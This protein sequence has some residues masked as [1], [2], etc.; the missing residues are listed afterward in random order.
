MVDMEA[1]AMVVVATGAV[2]VASVGAAGKFAAVR[3]LA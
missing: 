3:A 1:V 2:A